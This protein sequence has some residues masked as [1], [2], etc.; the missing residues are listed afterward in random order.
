MIVS[1]LFILLTARLQIADVLSLGV[2]G[3]AFLFVLILIARPLAVVASTWGSSLERREKL[4]LGAM[5]PRGI[6]AA[7]VASLFSI[8]LMERGVAGADRLVPITFL[9]ITGTVLVYGLL[10]GPLAR[11]LALSQAN[12]Q[13]VLFIGAHEWAR[14]IA[15]A[16]QAAGFRVV[17]VDTNAQN[18]R[19]AQEEGLEA[20]AVNVLHE[21]IME[22][23]DLGGIG[24]S[25]ALTA[26]DEVNS[27][28]TL[29]MAEIFGR[30]DVYQLPL[31]QNLESEALPRF[32]RGRLLFG[33]DM[34]FY[35]LRDL[36]EQ[37]WR[38]QHRVLSKRE[39]REGALK[40]LKSR[41]QLLFLITSDEAL[42]VYTPD[43][44]LASS[45]SDAIIVLTAPDDADDKAS[46]LVDAV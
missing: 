34:S 1:G 46:T 5:M 13:G 8:E 27:L 30:S 26:N 9:I 14:A 10:S 42:A 6:V 17:L 24:K 33:N 25:L 15:S 31:R 43:N 23:L 16:V 22:E 11:R 7:A 21:E 20:H 44:D 29:H 41:G 32:L 39:T 35:R 4:F 45:P 37:G 40:T 2:A 38:P 18:V 36:H 19:N 3:L 12:P 28:A